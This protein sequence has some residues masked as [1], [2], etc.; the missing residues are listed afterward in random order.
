MPSSNAAA[1]LPVGLCWGNAWNATLPELIDTAG[2]HGFGTLA[3]TPPAYRRWRERGG[4]EAQLRDMLAAAGT[5]V[6]VIDPLMRGLPGMPAP[7]EVPEHFRDGFHHDEAYCYEV[8]IASGA[9]IINIAHFLGKVTPL[10]E[11]AEAFGRIAERAARHG[12]A[13]SLEFIPDTGMPDL[14]TAKA[15]VEMVK[16]PNLGIMLDTWHLLRSGGTVEQIRSLA[17]GAIIAA[18]LSDRT[19]PPPGTAYVAMQ[20]RSLPGE[21]QAPLADILNAV[22]ANNPHI[23]VE[24]EV[25]N[26]ELRAM[27]ADQS[28]ER[29]ASA[30]RKW[31]E[32]GGKAV[33]WPAV[34]A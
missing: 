7:E 9:H 28:G 1:P 30:T 31:L 8:A 25:F 19:P 18:Q 22:F 24:L 4:T 26:A 29:S 14:L 6:A 5:R 11:L 2:K 23:S 20:G 34:A 33:R 27:T 13:V 12:L 15:L 10:P 3:I 32:G 16:L 17:P 21:G